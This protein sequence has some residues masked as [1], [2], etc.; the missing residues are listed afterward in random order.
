MKVQAELYKLK[1]SIKLSSGNFRQPY[2]GG[3]NGGIDSGKQQESDYVQMVLQLDQ[4]IRRQAKDPGLDRRN[5]ATYMTHFKS[6]AS[7]QQA[8]MKSLRLSNC[9]STIKHSKTNLNALDQRQTLSRREIVS[10]MY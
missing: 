3:A 2:Q 10:K 1:E 8:S 6:P 4:N 5:A 7:R 9:P